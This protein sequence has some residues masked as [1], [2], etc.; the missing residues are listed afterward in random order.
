MLQAPPKQSHLHAKL[1][2]ILFQKTG[3]VRLSYGVRTNTGFNK[4]AGIY[5]IGF[6]NFMPTLTKRKKNSQEKL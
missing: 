3:I 5:V 4:N 6:N 2:C 1:H